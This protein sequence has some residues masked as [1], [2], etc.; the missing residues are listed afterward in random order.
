MK[1]LFT[2]DFWKSFINNFKQSR[3]MLVRYLVV[4]IYLIVSSI[5]ANRLDLPELTYFN[6]MLT[7]SYIGEMIAF[8]FSEGYG[9]YLNQNIDD[10]GKVRNYARV[11]F[12]FAIGISL[13]VMVLSMIFSDVI[14]TRFFGL[15]AGLD[16]TFYYLMCG[17]LFLECVVIYLSNMFKKLSLFLY[18]MI[19]TVIQ[20]VMIVVGFS[21]L[22][23]GGGLHLNLIGI[24]YIV[25]ALSCAIY[26][27]VRLRYNKAHPINMF[28]WRQLRLTRSELKTTLGIA[29]SELSYEVGAIM[30]SMFILRVNEVVFNT[31]AY[32]ENVLDVLNGIF[33][34]YV[35]I[36]SLN[37]CRAIGRAEKDIAYR[38]AVY[39]IWGSLIIWIGYAIVSFALF[40]PLRAGM[41]A[42]LRATALLNMGLYVVLALIRFITWTLNTYVLPQ[43][44]KLILPLLLLEIF[45]VVYFVVFYF[46]AELLP[47]NVYLI[48]LIVA[49]ELIVKL[50]ACMVMLLGRRWLDSVNTVPTIADRK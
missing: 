17:Y 27:L 24:L 46:V 43:S 25:S 23:F 15:S 40:V 32:Y 31:Y 19:N 13:V 21:I 33:F 49:F 10:E 30:T 37:I 38:E 41:N 8:G 35:N 14:M 45:G 1:I 48:Y 16:K 11:G 18:Q 28:D 2:K 7:F 34:A 20:C 4:G 39:S 36:T 12:I 47:N 3:W 9:M 50:V 22:Y 44:D 5:F 26:N 42:E 29:L 6:A